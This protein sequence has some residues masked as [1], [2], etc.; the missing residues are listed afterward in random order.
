M[1]SKLLGLTSIL[2]KFIPDASERDKAMAEVE[3]AKLG[4]ASK[5]VERAAIPGLI[6]LLVISLFNNN[7]LVPWV[8]AIFKINIFVTPIPE[9]LYT[10]VGAIIFGLFG[11]KHLDKKA[12][13]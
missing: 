1:I 2:E 3:K 10:L 7:I 9:E 6:W 4:V 8:T 11:K 12:K 13:K 5:M